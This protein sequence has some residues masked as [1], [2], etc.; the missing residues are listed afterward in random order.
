MNKE[1]LLSVR[2]NNILTISLGVP[3]LILGIA[4]FSSP[5]FSQFWDFVSMAILGTV[6]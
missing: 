3:T 6:Y 4:G 5:I 2:V 1:Q